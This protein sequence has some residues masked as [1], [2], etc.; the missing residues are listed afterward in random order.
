MKARILYYCVLVARDVV[1]CLSQCDLPVTG[2]DG[3]G[4]ESLTPRSVLGRS[5]RLLRTTGSKQTR[6]SILYHHVSCARSHTK[7]VSIVREQCVMYAY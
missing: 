4:A 7:I 2:G 5:E 6:V 1:I 3:V